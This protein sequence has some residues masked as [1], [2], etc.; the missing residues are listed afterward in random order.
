MMEREK[1]RLDEALKAVHNA[2]V[3]HG[4]IRNTWLLLNDTFPGHK[5]SA[6]AVADFIS[7]CSACQKYRL[8]M[9]P[10]VRGFSIEHPVNRISYFPNCFFSFPSIPQLLEAR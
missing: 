8:G 5:V 1:D 2:H 6:K 3:G 7:T 9:S 4:G 10:P